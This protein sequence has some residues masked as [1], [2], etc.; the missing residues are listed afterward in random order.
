MLINTSSINDIIVKDFERT[1]NIYI[2]DS[3]NNIRKTL[4]FLKKGNYEE[5][6][7][8]C[9][10]P[11][12]KLVK[13]DDYGKIIFQKI[14][15]NID[16]N[17]LVDSDDEEDDDDSDDDG[18]LDEEMQKKLETVLT[19]LNILKQKYIMNGEGELIEPIKQLVKE[20]LLKAGIEIDLDNDNTTFSVQNNVQNVNGKPNSAGMFTGSNNPFTDFHK[21]FENTSNEKN[22]KKPVEKK[23]TKTML[24]CLPK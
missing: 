3:V 6:L 23:Q 22:D 1:I 16:V 13:M 21:H 2:S 10:R 17:E 11:F 20:A 5:E 19:N 12:R 24:P 18:E 9:S 4:D 8:S 14:F 15:P 7:L